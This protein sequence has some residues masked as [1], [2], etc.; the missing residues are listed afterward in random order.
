MVIPIGRLSVVIVTVLAAAGCQSQPQ[1]QPQVAS[2]PPASAFPGGEIVDL[3][4]PYDDTTIFWPTAAEG[5][6]LEK[7]ADGMTPG[8][9]YYAANNFSTA[10]HGGTH[11]DAPVHF[12]AVA[13]AGV[14][15]AASAAVLA[16]LAILLTLRPAGAPALAGAAVVLAGLLASYAL[17]TTTG[18]P[19]LHP[20]AEP[21]AERLDPPFEAD[22]E[23]AERVRRLLRRFQGAPDVNPPVAEIHVVSLVA[24]VDGRQL[25]QG[26]LELEHPAPVSEGGLDGV[27]GGRPGT[28]WRRRWSRR[29]RSSCPG[30][31]T[32]CPA[33]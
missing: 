33:G 20:E 4:H 19:L 26:E 24:E 28:G 8:G 21:V 10:E 29:C 11:L 3:S 31:R 9:Y 13:P 1:P 25:R 30:S 22:G 18:V 12:A 23:S 16:L 17:A 27:E 6:R 5:F 2:P 32:A 7:V 14:A 15:F